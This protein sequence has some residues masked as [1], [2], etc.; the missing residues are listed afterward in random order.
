ML[1]RTGKAG[2]SDLSKVQYLEKESLKEPKRSSTVRSYQ[3][4]NAPAS[5]ISPNAETKH[6]PQ[7]SMKTL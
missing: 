3:E 2:T 4:E 7:K 6:M 1:F 5:T